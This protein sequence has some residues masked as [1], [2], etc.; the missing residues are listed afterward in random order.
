MVLVV[1]VLQNSHL[2]ITTCIFVVLKMKGSI[3]ISA[4]DKKDHNL[5]PKATRIEEFI[6]WV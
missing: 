3:H 2:G 4:I 6:S 5:P 1:D